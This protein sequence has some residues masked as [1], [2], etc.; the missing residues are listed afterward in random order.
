MVA[1]ITIKTMVAVVE[2]MILVMMVLSM[3]VLVWD[4]FFSMHLL[5][6][7]EMQV[8]C[9]SLQVPHGGSQPSQ[10]RNGCGR[11]GGGRH[12]VGDDGSTDDGPHLRSPLQYAPAKLNRDASHMLPV[13]CIAS[14]STWWQPSCSRQWWCSSG[15]GGVG[16]HIFGN[17][18]STND[19]PH[20]G[21]LFGM[22]LLI[23]IEM[24]IRPHMPLAASL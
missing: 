6:L 12:V 9:A 19:G 1:A 23:L 11:G 22:C 21:L 13:R 18:G 7:I 3:M 10:S 20:L 8:V 4:L 24:Q 16:R 15:G 17:N 2:E 14:I 5:I